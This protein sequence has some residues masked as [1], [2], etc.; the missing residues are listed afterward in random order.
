MNHRDSI[1]TRLLKECFG[2]NSI[3]TLFAMIMPDAQY[4]MDT[5]S[6]LKFASQCSLVKQR[7]QCNIDPIIQVIQG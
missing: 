7:V 5:L 2:G 1:L 6:T 4:D 3:T